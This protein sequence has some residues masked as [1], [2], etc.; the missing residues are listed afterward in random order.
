M[1]VIGKNSKLLY[2]L[3]ISGG[4]IDEFMRFTRALLLGEN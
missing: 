1:F 2:N 3:F 4:R